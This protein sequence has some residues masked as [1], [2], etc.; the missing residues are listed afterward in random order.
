MKEKYVGLTAGTIL[1][2]YQ[3]VKEDIVLIDEPPLKLVAISFKTSG[4]KKKKEVTVW[5]QNSPS[6]FDKN[7]RWALET[8]RQATVGDIDVKETQ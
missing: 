2:D 7:R 5:L 1:D 6:L 3:L 8:I 4:S